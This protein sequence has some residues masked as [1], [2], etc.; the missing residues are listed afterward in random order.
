MS[1]I[2]EFTI[3]S[4]EF[5]LGDVLEV[6]PE[7]HISVERLVPAGN[8]VMPYVWVSDCDFEKFEREVRASPHVESLAALDRVED[9]VLYRAVWGAEVESLINGFAE[10]NATI[11]EAEG[12]A[13]WSFRV[14]FDGHAD[15]TDFHNYC[16]DHDIGYTVDR[17]YT[18]TDANPNG[19]DFGLT[20]EQ[21]EALLLAV[22]SGY[23][24]VPRKVTLDALAAEFGISQQAVSER[25]RRGT[26]KVLS[27]VLTERSAADL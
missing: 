10:T 26:G 16:V 11:L 8:R 7:I 3:P 15:L 14:R 27:S 20:N 1:V 5:I 12:N 4:E 23:F 13:V 24:D 25:V 21:R 6:N 17:I 9:R 22:E 2:A 18:L 19:H